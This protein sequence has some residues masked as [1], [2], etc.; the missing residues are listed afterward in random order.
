MRRGSAPAK[1]AGV[2]TAVRDAVAGLNAEPH[3]GIRG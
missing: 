1:S 3:K 2:D